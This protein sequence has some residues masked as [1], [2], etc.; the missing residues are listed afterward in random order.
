MFPLVLCDVE[1]STSAPLQTGRPGLTIE[2]HEVPGPS[3]MPALSAPGDTTSVWPTTGGYPVFFPGVNSPARPY[4]WHATAEGWRRDGRAVKLGL[5]TVHELLGPRPRGTSS[6]TAQ[7]VS[8]ANAWPLVQFFDLV[9]GTTY[10]FYA[11]AAVALARPTAITT[12]T[13]SLPVAGPL[14]DWQA[15]PYLTVVGRE[16]SPTAARVRAITAVSRAAGIDTVTLAT[17]LDATVV[18]HRDRRLPCPAGPVRGG[19]P[20]RAVA[21][22]QQ[23]VPVIRP[24]RAAGRAAGGRVQ[25]VRNDAEELVLHRVL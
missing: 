11:P 20:G 2:A 19:R 8:R 10:P 16:L 25:P 6:R 14:A 21:D 17:P 13:V 3:A 15:Y 22:Q 7:A 5:G 23:L 18:T 12:T 9:R 4:A 1:L 24:D